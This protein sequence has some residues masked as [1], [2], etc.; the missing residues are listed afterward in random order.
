MCMHKEACHLSNVF[1]K[2]N[3]QMNCNLRNWVT[4]EHKG[5][6]SLRRETYIVNLIMIQISLFL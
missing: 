2:V 6:I 1:L 3:Q 4:T 5:L